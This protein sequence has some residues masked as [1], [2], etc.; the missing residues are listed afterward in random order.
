MKV[1]TD[2]HMPLS[3]CTNC[4]YVLDGATGVAEDD[5]KGDLV[6]DPGDFTICVYCGHLMI[7]TDTLTMRDLTKDEM[8]KVAGDK[9]MIAIQ[10]AR[11]R[12]LRNRAYCEDFVRTTIKETMKQAMPP[13]WQINL[14]V[15]KVL[16]AVPK[17]PRPPR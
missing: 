14:T 10:E 9:R 7:F 4:G 8:I 17:P 16:A 12:V 3:A 11:A 1:G 13:D 15:D 5:H 6:P 2:H